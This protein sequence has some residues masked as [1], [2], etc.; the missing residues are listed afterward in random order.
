M[1]NVCARVSLSCTE[2]PFAVHV[3]GRRGTDS[4]FTAANQDL[5]R[6]KAL[7]RLLNVENLE[8]E[9]IAANRRILVCWCGWQK[10]CHACIVA[11][12]AVGFL[13]ITAVSAACSAGRA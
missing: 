6:Y 12:F 11:E 5:V 3:R 8:L 7:H 4:E 10:P 13:A 9:A 2:S 1:H